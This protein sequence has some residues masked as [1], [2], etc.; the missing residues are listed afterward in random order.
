MKAFFPLSYDVPTARSLVISLVIYL[1]VGAVASW[2]GKLLG[3]LPI[4]GWLLR[5]VLWVVSLYCVVGFVLALLVFF[6]IIKNA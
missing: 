1:V 3:K 4:I 2:L 5:I 6:K